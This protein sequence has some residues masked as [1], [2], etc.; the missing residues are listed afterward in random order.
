MKRAFLGMLLAAAPL[1]GFAQEKPSAPLAGKL[2]ITGSSTMAPLVED[3]AKRFRVRNPG[4]AIPIAR[5]GVV[6]VVHKDKPV[7]GL[8]RTRAIEVFTGTIE[9]DSEPGKGSTF[10]PRLPMRDKP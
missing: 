4:V 10:T 5:D 9:V 8:A 6:F 7:R 3:L 2:L 1:C